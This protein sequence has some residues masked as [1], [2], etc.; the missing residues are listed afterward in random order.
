MNPSA[1][2]ARMPQPD[3]LLIDACPATRYA[4]RLE[5]LSLGASVRQAQSV[6]EA[7]PALRQ[8]RPDLIIS[9]PVLPGL[10]ALDLLELLRNADERDTPPVIIHCPAGDW[11]LAEAATSRGAL[12]VVDTAALGAGIAGWISTVQ[13][14]ATRD[15]SVPS[16]HSASRAPRVT[17]PAGL[18]APPAALPENVPAFLPMR[19]HQA[20]AAPTHC[21]VPAL[22]GALLGLLIGLWIAAMLH[23]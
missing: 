9:S 11:P 23:P 5:L 6:E 20:G 7:L 22:A 19:D 14:R 12:A 4:L 13:P 18:P 17:A 15:Q 10:N 2:P 8:E 21:W 3:V 1:R 16:S